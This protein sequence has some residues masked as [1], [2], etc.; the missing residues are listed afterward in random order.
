MKLKHLLLL[1][2]IRTYKVECPDTDKNGKKIVSL[3]PHFK[4]QSFQ[5][6]SLT[7]IIIRMSKS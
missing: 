5:F 1:L 6:M 3:S 4:G 7:D 2:L